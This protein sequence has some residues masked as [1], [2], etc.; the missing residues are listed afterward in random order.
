MKVS[1]VLVVLQAMAPF[2]TA[3]DFDNVG[4]LIGDP[5]R[6]VDAVLVALD[7]TP[8]A[9]RAAR[10]AGAQLLLTHHPV[11][12]APRKDLRTDD[13]EG[14]LLHRIIREDLCLAAMHTNWDAAAGGVNDALLAALGFDTAAADGMLRAADLPTPMPLTDLAARVER[15]LG[16]A[17]RCCAASDAPVSRLAVC[18]GAGGNLWPQAKA[19]GADCLLVGECRYHHALDAVS[20]GLHVLEAGHWATEQP[21]ALALAQGLQ[22]RLHALQYDVRVV[23]MNQAPFGRRVKAY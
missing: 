10:Q 23:C 17:V 5:D 2:E 6:P 13:P 19:L 16:D 4:L 18:G 3:M 12:L 7:A 1:D 21:G 15:R 14:A 11:L 9:V 22:S 8:A 20:M